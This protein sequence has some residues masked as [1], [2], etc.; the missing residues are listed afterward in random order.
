MTT[1]I[2]ETQINNVTIDGTEV[3]EVTSDGDVVYTAIPS[4]GV[5]KWNCENGNND[6]SVVEDVWFDNDGTVTNASYSNTLG[7]D[8]NGAYYDACDINV[9]VSGVSGPVSFSGW[10]FATWPEG[11]GN[12][13]VFN[14]DDSGRK[15]GV[16][17]NNNN[18]TGGYELLIDGTSI[19]SNVTTAQ[20]WIHIIGTYD[21]SGNAKIYIN[22][23]LENSASG[24]TDPTD[25]G[26]LYISQAPNEGKNNGLRIAE[27]RQYSKVLSDTEA[28][29]IYNTGSIDG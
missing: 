28:S 13:I 7:N 24:L 4:S 21:G 29:N 3:Q 16:H 22:G 25:S 19:A 17:Y 5:L 18:N 8:S 11:D 9:G 1:N 27:F 12:K 23:N 6:T 26:T 20:S 2:D 10:F 15:F 14:F